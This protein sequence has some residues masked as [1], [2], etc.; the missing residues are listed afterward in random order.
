MPEPTTG[1]MKQGNYEVKFKG[2]SISNVVNADQAKITIESEQTSTGEKGPGHT[3]QGTVRFSDV[4]IEII[5]TAST[6][7][8]LFKEFRKAQN[9]PDT[10]K[11]KGDL[12]IA[13]K[14]SRDET[15]RSQH[16]DGCW[17][18]EYDPPDFDATNAQPMTESYT[19]SIDKLKEKASK[20]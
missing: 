5:M 3:R 16:Y 2:R 12:I 13:N 20:L 14:N 10:P 19:F 11:V 8:Y 7:E 9:E 15:N 6:D 1:L 4:T 17:I 18:K